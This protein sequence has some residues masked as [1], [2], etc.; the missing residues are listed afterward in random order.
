MTDLLNAIMEFIGGLFIL[1]H[2]RV[3]YKDKMV[4]G[5]S[6]ISLIFFTSWAFWNCYYYPS[7]NQLYSTIGA[8]F[9]GLSNL[10]YVGL[11]I[12]YRKKRD[13]NDR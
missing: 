11:V 4:N 12:Y 5:V 1:N 13:L 7:L 9:M 3:L 6:I 10:L 8:G 2:A